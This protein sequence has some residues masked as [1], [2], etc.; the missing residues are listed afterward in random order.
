[1]NTRSLEALL[2]LCRKGSPQYPFCYLKDGDIKQLKV[3]GYVTQEGGSISITENGISFIKELL[4]EQKE[5]RIMNKYLLTFREGKDVGRTFT[6]EI[7]AFC[8]EDAIAQG[9]LSHERTSPK[10]TLVGCQPVQPY[11]ITSFTGY[12]NTAS[13]QPHSCP[14][15]VGRGFVASG[16]Y[17]STGETFLSAG[18]TEPCKSCNGT[19]F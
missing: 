12:I 5:N 13:G 18:G 16:F 19:I 9:R 17:S 6:Q 3:L 14:V 15:C 11:S 8:A 1:M 2:Q 10:P 4:S 7:D